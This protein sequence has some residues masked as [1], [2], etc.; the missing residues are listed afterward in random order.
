MAW[1]VLQEPFLLEI[2]FLSFNASYM[3]KCLRIVSVSD[4]FVSL[5]RTQNV[6]ETMAIT[7]GSVLKS[8]KYKGSHSVVQ[9]VNHLIF[10]AHNNRRRF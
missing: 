5:D 2:C 8:I 3:L 10:H 6:N 7:S 1:E 4:H 9:K